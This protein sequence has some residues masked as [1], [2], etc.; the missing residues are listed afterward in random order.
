[1]F[2]IVRPWPV[3]AVCAIDTGLE[4]DRLAAARTHA[5]VMVCCERPGGLIFA[6]AGFIKCALSMS[7]RGRPIEIPE[8][9]LLD[10]AR[11]VLLAKGLRAT[12]AEIAA[13]AGVSEGLVFYRYRS[14]EALLVAVVRREHALPARLGELIARAGTGSLTE[15]LE[16]LGGVVMAGV[17]ATM[18]F[19]D[20]ARSSPNYPRV[21]K[22]LMA[23][24]A[25]PDRLQATIA[26]YVEAEMAAGRLRRLDP[27]L[28]SRTLFGAVLD[29]EIGRRIR[30]L[31]PDPSEDA[32]FVRALV[33]LL[34]HGALPERGRRALRSRS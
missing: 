1:M 8:D 18:P 4:L 31:P 9:K 14:K 3:V 32:A 34:L 29:R 2:A 24:G 23:A 26:R 19:V 20:L 25:T 16:E 21:H 6:P 12:T 13:K 11:E 27:A 22:L 28:L 33:E 30:A 17:R 5:I 7:R 15:F 10:A